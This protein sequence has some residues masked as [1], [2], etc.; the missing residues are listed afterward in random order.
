MQTI[1]MVYAYFF[2]FF[3]NSINK[4]KDNFLIK[5]KAILMILILE[6]FFIGSIIVYVI[7]LFKYKITNESHLEFR[8]AF[9]IPL[10]ALKLWFFYKND[11]WE[12]YLAEFSQW[13][14]KKQ[15]KWDWLV[16]LIILIVIVNFLLSFYIY[17]HLDWNV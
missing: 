7:D 11:N 1:K 5:F 10:I 2:Y 17:A 3:Y 6:V 16:R 8:L 14:Q 9:I 4:V 13:P 15:K 12:K